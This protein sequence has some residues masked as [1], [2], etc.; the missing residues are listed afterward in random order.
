[1][2]CVTGRDSNGYAERRVRI[3]RGE[4][5]IHFWQKHCHTSFS[6]E[7]LMHLIFVPGSEFHTYDRQMN[8]I[9]QD[10]AQNVHKRFIDFITLMMVDMKVFTRTTVTMMCD[11]IFIF[12]RHLPSGSHASELLIAT[13]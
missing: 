12:H 10:I 2:A 6:E 3:V 13:C 4:K 11:T 9:S 7:N 5:M 1:V 8:V